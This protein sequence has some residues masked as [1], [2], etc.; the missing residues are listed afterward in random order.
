[1]K[2]IEIKEVEVSASE[3]GRALRL[4]DGGADYVAELLGAW[5]NGILGRPS[6]VGAELAEGISRE[7]RTLQQLIISTLFRTLMTLGETDPNRTDLR[8]EASIEACHKL[9]QLIES[10]DIDSLFPLV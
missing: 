7:H 5:M 3:L 9:K 8:N 1:M 6:D 2:S 10:G 4:E